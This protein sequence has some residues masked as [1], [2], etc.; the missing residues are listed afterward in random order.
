MPGELLGA[1]GV[2]YSDLRSLASASHIRIALKD[3]NLGLGAKP[4]AA[5]NSSETTGLDVFQDL[6]GRLN[7]R[8]T[9]R[10]PRD[11]TQ[12]SDLRSSAYIEQRW[13]DLRFV[14]GGFLVGD[15]LKG[16]AKG[17]QDALNDF[18]QTRSHHLESGTLAEANIEV[19]SDTSKRGKHKERKTSGD[20]HSVNEVSKQVD[21]RPSGLQSRKNLSME[22]EGWSYTTPRDMCDQLQTD[23]ARRYAGRAE[24]KLKRQAKRD[25]RHLSKVR[26]R[27]SILPSPDLIQLSGLD[28][29][30]LAVA[31]HPFPE[32]NISS[33]VS[34]D[35][36]AGRLSVR[37]RYIQQKKMSVVDHKALNE[38]FA[39]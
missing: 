4:D 12:R 18:Q 3:D 32:T 37:H 26:E 31:P 17:D 16:F 10:V 39:V 5:P 24:R 19:Q 14:S 15:T 28:V 25:A 8:A 1:S 13:G 21:W 2:A 6:L 33:R 7:G 9:T 27:S 30:E 29:G 38:V 34:H 36:E 22:P 35:L 20:N 11:R 23:K